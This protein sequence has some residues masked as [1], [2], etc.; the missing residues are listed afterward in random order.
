MTYIYNVVYPS[1]YPEH[2][3]RAG[4][5]FVVAGLSY[6]TRPAPILLLLIHETALWS[7]PQVIQ[8]S[9]CLSEY[10]CRARPIVEA[11]IAVVERG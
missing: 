8:S 4:H 1:H 11:V 10:A 3:H 5:R 7:P 2:I 9:E 6:C